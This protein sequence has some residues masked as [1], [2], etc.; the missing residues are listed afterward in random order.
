MKVFADLNT[1]DTTGNQDNIDSDLEAVAKERAKMAKSATHR[2][3]ST[4]ID[5]ANIR[6]PPDF[7]PDWLF[8]Y[9]DCFASKEDTRTLKDIYKQTRE[10]VDDLRKSIVYTEEPAYKVLWPGSHKYCSTEPGKEA[11]FF[12][13]IQPERLTVIDTAQATLRKLPNASFPRYQSGEIQLLSRRTWKTAKKRLT[14]I[15]S[16]QP[17]HALLLYLGSAESEKLSTAGFLTR[18]KMRENFMRDHAHK[19]ANMWTTELHLSFYKKI[20]ITSDDLRSLPALKESIFEDPEKLSAFPGKS[21]VSLDKLHK[22][23][24]GWRFSGDL[25][26]RRWTGTILTFTPG[27]EDAEWITNWALE[28]GDEYRQRKIIE[29]RLLSEITKTIHVSTREILRDLNVVLCEGDGGIYR[30]SSEHHDPLSET[31]DQSYSRSKLYLQ[32]SDFLSHLD[33]SFKNTMETIEAYLNREKQRP[34]QP[35]WSIGDERQYRPELQKWDQEGKKN[36]ALLWSIRNEIGTKMSRVNR[37]R[38]SLNADMQLRETRLQARSAEDVRL[39]TYVTII[40]LPI[41]FSS[42]LFSMSKAPDNSLVGNFAKV[43]VIALVITFAILLNLKTMSRNMWRYFNAGLHKISDT[44]STS[45]WDFWKK[46]HIGLVQAEKRNI[47]SDEPLEV[48][49]MSRWW[50]CLFSLVFVL[51]ELPAIRVLLAWDVFLP[52]TQKDPK[53]PRI[54]RKIIRVFLGLFCLPLFVFSFAVLFLLW[55]FIDLLKFLSS[56]KPG[57]QKLLRDSETSSQHS[58]IVKKSKMNTVN[59][60][61]NNKGALESKKVE[62]ASLTNNAARNEEP[63]RAYEEKYNARVMRLTQPP[64]LFRSLATASD[65]RSK[66]ATN[67]EKDQDAKTE[68]ENRHSPRS[69]N[70][71][72]GFLNHLGLKASPVKES[73]TVR[74]N[75]DLE[76]NDEQGSRAV[77]GVVAD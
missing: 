36:V 6:D 12:E 58:D 10:E 24:I 1:G 30:G 52:P 19:G 62:V 11:T 26:D 75:A 15:N 34:V 46:A 44:M 21:K 50:Y 4:K 71:I 67:R 27:M 61:T 55:N 64:S 37:L 33:D 41:S 73:Q 8:P 66:G 29:A 31:F 39:F 20:T 59:D 57:K 54:L 43:A 45:S 28:S 35:R 5:R 51:W 63:I 16:C 77:H 9:P 2:A 38:E 25:H 60:G 22:G 23:A 7:E 68:G 69:K 47:Q 56:P 32:L 14:L 76:S 13:S 48:R 65:R 49:K 18:H 74:K 42:S 17:E 70:S 3:R 72:M 53:Q 40:F